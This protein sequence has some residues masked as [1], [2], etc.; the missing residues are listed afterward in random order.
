MFVRSGSWRLKLGIILK[1]GRST[2]EIQLRYQWVNAAAKK[3]VTKTPSD[4][5]KEMVD[6]T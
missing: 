4:V 1:N 2:Q 3:G 6:V 5:L